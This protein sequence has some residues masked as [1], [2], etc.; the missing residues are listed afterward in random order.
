MSHL[1]P[2]ATEVFST[3]TIT[4]NAIIRGDGGSRNIQQSIASIDDSG[5]LTLSQQPSFLAYLGTTATNKT[6]NGTSY[7]LGTDALTEVYDRGG[8]F[9]TN[10]TFTAPVTGLYDLTAQITITGATMATSFVISIVTTLRTYTSTFTRAILATD[11]SV[12]ISCIAD[13]TAT[14][15]ATVTIVG[16]GEV[17]DTD[18]IK[19]GAALE[20]YFCGMLLA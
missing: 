9:N 5:R 7:T 3:S 2:E 1:I 20:T 16:S 12:M 8:D 4:D 14:N 6:G 10:G 15:T 13:M 18:D 11:Q 19:G 17:A